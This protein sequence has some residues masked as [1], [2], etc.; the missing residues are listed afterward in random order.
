MPPKLPRKNKRTEAKLDGKVAEWLRKKHPHR[1]WLLEVKMKGGR[2]LDHQ[3]KALWQVEQG[4]FLWKPPDMGNRNPGDYIY[5]GDADAIYC[6]IDGKD[7]NCAVNGGV[8]KY[9]FKV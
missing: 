9:K 1:N 2:L 6:V 4:T 7:V 5:L 8:I 3:K